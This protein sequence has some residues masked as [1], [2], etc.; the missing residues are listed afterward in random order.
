MAK[1][2]CDQRPNHKPSDHKYYKFVGWFV[3]VVGRFDS[4]RGDEP[5]ISI[6]R[7]GRNRFRY[8]ICKGTR[9]MKAKMFFGAGD[10]TSNTTWRSARSRFVLDKR[11]RRR[12]ESW[13]QTFKSLWDATLNSY[14]KCL[15][16]VLR[17]MQC[18]AK[19]VRLSSVDYYRGGFF[20]LYHIMGGGIHVKICCT[21]I[22]C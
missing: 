12:V 8:I 6:T 18:R 13:R 15:A 4:R 17:S 1:K 10:V 11:R 7:N 19:A 5:W 20:L 14:R 9:D 2:F 16:K 22:M 3:A 21:R